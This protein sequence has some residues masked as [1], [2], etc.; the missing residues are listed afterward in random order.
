M[1]SVLK[2]MDGGKARTPWPRLEEAER[3]T[4]LSTPC[5][6]R[7]LSPS[8]ENALFPGQNTRQTQCFQVFGRLIGA[9]PMFFPSLG[10]HVLLLG[11]L[12]ISAA[13]MP[14]GLGEGPLSV[15]LTVHDASC[16][17][18]TLLPTKRPWVGFAVFP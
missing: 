6:E 1:F 3:G 10:I 12:G 14:S 5:R 17:S 18:A 13:L 7:T 11:I 4:G 9:S 16:F 15:Y 2:Q 8:E